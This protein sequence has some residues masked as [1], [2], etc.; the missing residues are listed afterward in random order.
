MINN[1][2]SFKLFVN[3]SESLG[4][5]NFVIGDYVYY[6]ANYGLLNMIT[7]EKYKIR[8]FATD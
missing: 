7:G 8:I 6:P 5:E 2:K 3:T 1:L 4:V